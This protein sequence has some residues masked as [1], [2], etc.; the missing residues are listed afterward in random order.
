MPVTRT[1]SQF[2]LTVPPAYFQE[3][4]PNVKIRCVAAYCL[5]QALLSSLDLLMTQ[6]N[7]DNHSSVLEC[8]EASRHFASS[9]VKDEAISTAFQEALLS[10]WGDG[11][12]MPDESGEATARLSLQHG[13]AV[14]FLAQEAG[15]TK[16][17]L[18]FLSALYLDPVKATFAESH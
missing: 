18:H 15:A 14:F 1:F 3:T 10:D 8:L 17:L 7:E 12:G 16:T 5:H 2:Y 11:M 4:V 6:I 13:S 9:A